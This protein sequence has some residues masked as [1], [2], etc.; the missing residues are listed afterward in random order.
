MEHF[1]CLF[2]SIVLD[3]TMERPMNWCRIMDFVITFAIG[4]TFVA[5]HPA[6]FSE[7]FKV[8][9]AANHVKIMAD[10]SIE[11]ILDKNSGAGFVSKH[12]Y[13]FG[14]VSM[15]I[16]LVAGDSAGTVAAFYMSSDKEEVRDELDFEFLGNRSGQPYTVQ[17]NVYTLGKGGREQRV[18]LWFDPSLEFHNY[19]ILWNHYHILFSVD[20]IP[21]RV[22]KNNKARGVPFPRNQM[23]AIFS[24]LWQADNWATRGGIEKIDW[25]KAPFVAAYR[26][27]EIDS[28]E[29]PG[30]TSCASNTKNWWEGLSYSNLSPNQVRLY[31]WVKMNHMIYDYCR[32]RSRYPE[33]PTECIAGI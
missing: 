28:C 14:L 16:K 20:E 31:E 17:T 13:M 19:S 11:L 24:T 10:K 18:N 23:M 12:E 29:F 15:K 25:R 6:L 2:P 7:D 5:A 21:I 27:F 1:V 32:D 22:Y 4:L 9:S 30:N 8:T 3:K 26:D 33:P